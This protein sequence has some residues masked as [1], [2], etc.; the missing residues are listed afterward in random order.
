MLPNLTKAD[1]G[2]LTI[3]IQHESPGAEKEANWLPAPEKGFWM[4]IRIY[5]PKEEALK[6]DWK[7]PAVERV[8]N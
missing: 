3:Y 5:W 4:P 8:K 2:S 6:G 7:A 1:D